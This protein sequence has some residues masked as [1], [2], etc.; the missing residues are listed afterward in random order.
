MNAIHA[1]AAAARNSRSEKRI[2]DLLHWDQLISTMEEALA[3]FSL[4]PGAA[5]GAQH[6]D[7][8]GGK[9]VSRHH[10]GGGR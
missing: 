10:A 7:D 4:G 2:R 3:A 5:A 6:A 8:R 1:R 9:A